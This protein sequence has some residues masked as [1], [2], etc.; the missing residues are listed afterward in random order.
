MCANIIGTVANQYQRKPRNWDMIR[1]EIRKA[2]NLVSQ[3]HIKNS[4]ML[5]QDA[6]LYTKEHMESVTMQRLAPSTSVSSGSRTTTEEEDKKIMKAKE[7]EGKR[8]RSE[9]EKADQRRAEREIQE[10][11]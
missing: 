8:R 3:F 5:V 9:K 11:Q 10:E 2:A 6:G 1:D 4:N 7:E